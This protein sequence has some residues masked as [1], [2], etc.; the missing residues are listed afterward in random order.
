MSRSRAV[1][2][3]LLV[4]LSLM[5][6]TSTA[7]GQQS[8][9]REVPGARVTVRADTG[10]SYDLTLWREYALDE[11]GEPQFNRFILQGWATTPELDSFPIQIFLSTQYLTSRHN[12]WAIDAAGAT[13][14]DTR[15][16]ELF[17]TDAWRG[18][19]AKITLGDDRVSLAV[20]V[21][22]AFRSVISTLDG[23]EPVASE[24]VFWY[25]IASM[26][27]GTALGNSVSY[28][29]CISS[30]RDTCK[31]TC[32]AGDWRHCVKSVSY[33]AEH[34]SC[35]F[36]CLAFDECCGTTAISTP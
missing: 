20:S 35:S 13:G 12:D 5:F 18:N 1:A 10:W 8:Q 14:I 6:C 3:L 15:N 19:L 25:S 9:L 21:S 2:S 28:S 32:S 34:G 17:R 31:Q 36:T 7:W 27:E 29:S 23:F 16:G 24:I 26:F 30:A 33:D 11:S 22:D 4:A